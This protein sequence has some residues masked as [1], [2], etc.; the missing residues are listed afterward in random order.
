MHSAAPSPLTMPAIREIRR[1]DV[2]NVS[3]LAARVWRKHYVPAIVSAEQIDYMIPRSCSE[4]AILKHMD[5]KKQ[6]GWLAHDGEHLAGYV[7]V[8]PKENAAW[9]I[10]KL[11][12]DDTRQRKGI[13]AALLQ[14]IISA[15]RPGELRLRVNRKNFTAINFYFTHGFSI[16]ALD[17]LDIGSGFVMD[18]FLM[19]KVL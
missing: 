3:A 11:Y 2:P 19:K 6:R 12:V 8:E 9:F 5:E 15:L 4:A 10:D 18:D 1:D 14:H 13:G 16:Y 17:V 7:V